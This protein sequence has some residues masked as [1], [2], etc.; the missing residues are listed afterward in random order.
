MYRDLDASGSRGPNLVQAKSRRPPFENSKDGSGS[1]HVRA[2]REPFCCF[3]GEFVGTVDETADQL[4]QRSLCF[5]RPDSYEGFRH[6]WASWKL[7]RPERVYSD[8]FPARVGTTAA[9]PC[10][11]F[12]RVESVVRVLTTSADLRPG[13]FSFD[14]DCAQQAINSRPPNERKTF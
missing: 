10:G 1:K 7:L 2:F 6:E 3:Q 8:E 5:T 4:V 9:L 11:S 14:Y 12:S 13:G